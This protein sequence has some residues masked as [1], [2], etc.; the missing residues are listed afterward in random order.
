MTVINPTVASITARSLFGR[1][2]ALLLI[3]LPLLLIILSAAATTSNAPLT[4][5]VQPLIGGIG[6]GVAVP[7]VALIIGTSVIGSEID[8]GT[9]VHIL[10]KPLSRASIVLAKVA[11]AALVTAAVNGLMLFV[12]GAI[13]VSLRFGV[14]VAVAGVIAS[15]CY[16]ALFVMLSLLTRRPALVGLLYIVVWE[17]LLGNFLTGTR[18]LSI[19]QMAFTF[20]HKISGSTLIHT[21][22][23]L[24]IAI[25]MSAVFVV[26]STL[27]AIDRLRS[28]T[29]AGETS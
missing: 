15:V 26:G 3:P 14:A 29:L 17:G 21:T 13:A 12:S 22:V 18:A 28:F 11:V 27:I 23:S 16:S 25:V 24:P 8:D 10:T 2:R 6:F 19:E 1:K 7:I 5:W 4:D 20:V 9:I